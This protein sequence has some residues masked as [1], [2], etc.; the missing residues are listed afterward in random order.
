MKKSSVSLKKI[1]AN[2]SISHFGDA[3][4]GVNWTCF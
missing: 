2:D 4:C 3:G 1:L